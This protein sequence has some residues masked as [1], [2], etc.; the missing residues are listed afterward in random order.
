M[1]DN[2]LIEAIIALPT[3]LFYNTPLTTYIWVLSKNKRAERKG[4]VQLIDASLIFHKL[5]KGLGDKKNEISPADRAEITRVYAAFTPSE[6]CKIFNNDDFLYR[7][8][9]V[10]Q[11]LQRNYAITDAR[12]RKMVQDGGLSNLYDESKVNELEAAEELSGKELKKLENYQQ[13][14]PL[15][16][17]IIDALTKAINEEKV[18]R[19]IKDFMPVLSAALSSAT[20]DKKLLERIAAGLSMM[21]KTAEIQKDKKGNIIFDKDTKDTEIVKYTENIDDYMTRE[22]W[23]YL[24]DA[25]AFFEEN[26]SAKKPV[27]KTGAEISFTRL[28]YKYQQPVPSEEL[29]GQFLKIEESVSKRISDLFK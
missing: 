17:A 7:E 10:M 1:L 9:A 19:S 16:D 3:D 29:E 12:I 23:P 5:R 22:V 13:N 18:Y 27:I 20:S 26:L 2:D 15:F 25:R 8:Y 11:P 14:K 24:P 21:D 6:I 28:F 4:K